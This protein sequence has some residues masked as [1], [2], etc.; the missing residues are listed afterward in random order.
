MPI[1]Y[2]GPGRRLRVLATALAAVLALESLT[3]AVAW[4]E[5]APAFPELLR[6]A[7]TAPRT[8]EADAG[9]DQ[10]EGQLRQAGTRPNPEVGISVESFAGSGPYRGF[11]Q[12]ETTV[13]VSQTFELGGKRPARVGSA[14]AEL[15]VARARRTQAR[16]DLAHDLAIAYAE[17]EAAARK[18]GQAEVALTLAMEDA[19]IATAFVEAGREAEVRAIQAR[20]A[21]AAARA[22]LDAA[23]VAADEALARLSAMSGA[24]MPFT[25]LSGSLLT[26]SP[27][28][29]AN[30]SI[31]VMT[32]PAVIVAIAE[33]DAAA[34][35]VQVERTRAAPD[36]T[37]SV[38]ARRYAGDDA[39]ALVAGV[40]VPL[41]VFDQNRGAVSAAQAELRAA[42]ARL[43]GVRGEAE[44]DIRIGYRQIGV[45][46]SQ[47]AAAAEVERAAE[48][49]YRLTRIGY[50]SGRLPLS[51]VVAARRAL[52]EARLRT[53]D[54]QLN[55]VRAEAAIARLQ[56]RAPFGG[57]L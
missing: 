52:S 27:P 43:D 44:A 10:A 11:D 34:S 23:K 3:P 40:S 32:V 41:P 12:A 51:E 31:D 4:S 46:E 24:A 39:T 28:V 22:D 21:V 37:V 1:P 54:A 14:R 33:R 35:R 30:T 17:A 47:V 16:A 13:E 36:A 29:T 6:A 20:S 15:A 25:S 45:A 19:R 5:P 42:E 56:G 18:V 49:V 8:R 38:G 26:L 7:E 57:P 53:L 9:V 2:S 48:E 55:R 50:E